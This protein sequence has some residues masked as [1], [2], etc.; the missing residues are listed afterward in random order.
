MMG[1]WPKISNWPRVL[2]WRWARY[3]RDDLRALLGPNW[4]ALRDLAGGAI[5]VARHKAVR[6]ALTERLSIQAKSATGSAG[7]VVAAMLLTAPLSFDKGEVTDKGS[8][9]QRAVLRERADF[10]TALW[11]NHP[12]LILA[13]WKR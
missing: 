9:N 2:G 8:I 10:V 4:A 12:D 5:D 6:R 1:V 3:G 11:G 7:R 13:D